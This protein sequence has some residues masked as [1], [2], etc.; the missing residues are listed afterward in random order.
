MLKIRSQCINLI[1]DKVV[2]LKLKGKMSLVTNCFF[3]LRKY[4]YISLNIL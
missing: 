2:K 3:L 1:C 4:T